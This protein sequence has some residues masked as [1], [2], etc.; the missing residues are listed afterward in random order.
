[1]PSDWKNLL[2]AVEYANQYS[3]QPFDLNYVAIP[4]D[5]WEDT[6]R[7]VRESSKKETANA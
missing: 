3:R 5:I 1:M 7:M 6:E 2:E 4:K